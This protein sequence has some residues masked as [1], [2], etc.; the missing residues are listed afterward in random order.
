MNDI[1]HEY[2]SKRL[3]NIDLSKIKNRPGPV[4]TISRAAG[5]S[6]SRMAH[7]LTEKINSIDSTSN[8]EIISK[9]ILHESAEKLKMHP[10]EVKKIFE[11]KDKG[12][13]DDIMQAFLSRDYYFERKTIK[14]IKDVIFNFAVEGHKVFV[15]RGAFIICNNIPN[16]LHIRITAPL[17]WRI[18]KVMIAKNVK[19]P[20]ANEIIKTI[21]TNRHNYLAA[22]KGSPFD[23]EDFDLTI[24]QSKF[25]S[26][27]I[28]EI[29]LQAIK[30]KDIID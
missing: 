26:D 20:E 6:C 30:D 24:N 7:K 5:C 28:I 2:M 13:F 17:D 3:N 12:F 23:H 27:Q 15:G 8:W 25:N 19:K 11:V 10:E 9:E 14:T 21:E 16:S 22:L 18:N 29:I 4:I 1:F